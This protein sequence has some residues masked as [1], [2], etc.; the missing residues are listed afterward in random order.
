MCNKDMCRSK[1][2]KH[3]K[4]NAIKICFNQIIAGAEQTYFQIV[5]GSDIT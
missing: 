2:K 4:L 1:M 3:P 5:K